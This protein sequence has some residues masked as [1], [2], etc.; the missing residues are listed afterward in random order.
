MAKTKT[1]KTLKG[2][3]I[4]VPKR[5]DFLSD[6]KKATTPTKKSEDRGPKQK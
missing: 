4:P 3:E 2:Y 1:Q 6:L 5:G